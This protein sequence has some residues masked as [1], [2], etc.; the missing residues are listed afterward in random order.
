MAGWPNGLIA[1]QLDSLIAGRLGGLTAGW[2]DGWMAG[3]LEAMKAGR[4]YGW[5]TRWMNGRM[6]RGLNG[7]MTI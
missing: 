3:R 5:L 1:K 2:P 4:L 6:N 7:W